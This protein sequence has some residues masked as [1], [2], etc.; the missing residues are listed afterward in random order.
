MTNKKNYQTIATNITTIKPVNTIISLQ[1][2]LFSILLSL[3]H[4]NLIGRIT[5]NNTIYNAYN[6]NKNIHFNIHSDLKKLSYSRFHIAT[7]I[8]T[9]SI[10]TIT[11]KIEIKLL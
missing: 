11:K 8:H 9:R 10:V 2:L 3:P 5:G 4:I 1:N 6:N 7:P